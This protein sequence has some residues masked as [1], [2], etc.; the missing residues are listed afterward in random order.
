MQLNN[1]IILFSIIFFILLSPV[2]AILETTNPS[3]T[4]HIDYS[5]IDADISIAYSS[6]IFPSGF[7]INLGYN[8][9]N[10]YDYEFPVKSYLFPG[11]YHFLI[12]ANDNDNNV[13]RTEDDLKI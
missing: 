13:I 7:K 11:T 9:Q 4:I 8:T 10:G 5:S 12:I 2:S 1:K 3:P 6:L